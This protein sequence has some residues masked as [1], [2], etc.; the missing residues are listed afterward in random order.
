MPFFLRSVGLS[1]GMLQDEES[2]VFGLGPCSV[3]P[4]FNDLLNDFN[5][6][7][8]SIL[9]LSG[10]FPLPMSC[11]ILT[12][13]LDAALQGF[14]AASTTESMLA[15]GCCYAEKLYGNLLW[16]LCNVSERLLSQSLEH[17]SCAIGFLLPILFKA[18][19]SHH[20]L[21]IAVCGRTYTLSG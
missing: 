14:Q 16:G 8:K 21:E 9:Y 5:L 3:S 10:S 1:M 15:N 4:G 13:I 17:R 11:H 2:D 7:K 6:D 20:S 18:F 19:A 12:L